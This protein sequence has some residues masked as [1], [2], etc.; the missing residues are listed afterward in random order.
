LATIG[1]VSA[2]DEMKKIGLFEEPAYLYNKPGKKF[3]THRM[4]FYFLQ[5]RLSTLYFQGER[6]E[7]KRIFSYLLKNHTSMTL[8]S[9]KLVLYRLFIFFPSR[10]FHSLTKIK[11]AAK[12]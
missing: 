6:K 3:D 9:S 11:S 8:A 4:I 1:D 10:F 7:F 12:N 5:H 2:I